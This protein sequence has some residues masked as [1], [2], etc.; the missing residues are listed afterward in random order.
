MTS[1]PTLPFEFE[2]EGTCV[3]LPK[4]PLSTPCRRH[5]PESFSAFLSFSA[6]CAP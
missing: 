6:A 1:A 2:F 4:T 3:P 5:S